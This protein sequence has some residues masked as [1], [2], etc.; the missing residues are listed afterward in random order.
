MNSFIKTIPVTKDKKRVRIE[1]NV[2]D[3]DEVKISMKKG[4]DGI[5]L[6]RTEYLF[7][8][9]KTIP[10]EQDQFNSIKKNSYAFKRKAINNKNIRRW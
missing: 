3:S 7:M 6:Y 5:G 4:I 10:S 1:A 9:K 8:N 2:D